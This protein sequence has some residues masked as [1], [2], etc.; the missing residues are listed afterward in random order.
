MASVKYVSATGQ[1]SDQPFDGFNIV[2]IEKVDGT[3]TVTKIRK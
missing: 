3:K 1:V 2:V